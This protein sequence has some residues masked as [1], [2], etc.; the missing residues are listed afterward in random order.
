MR[1]TTHTDYAMRL[2]MYLGQHPERLCT[3]AEI[4]QAHGISE[5]HLMKITHR[6]GLRGWIH[7]VRGKHGGMR[8]AMEPAQ[9]GLGAVLR[10]TE[11]D[12][13]LVECFGSHNTCTLRGY[14]RLTAIFEG[15]LHQF[16]D[17]LDSYTLADIL[18]SDEQ[19]PAR[20][21]TTEQPLKLARPAAAA[22]HHD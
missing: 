15:A 13:E 2:L 8:L 20:P 14:C 1:L 11:H 5:P 17:H 12:L 6:L 3:I 10:D 21:L 7:T 18:P 19:M 16:L 4:A 9:I 22:T